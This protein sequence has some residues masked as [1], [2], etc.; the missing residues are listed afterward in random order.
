LLALKGWVKAMGG[1][2]RGY[3]SMLIVRPRLPYLDPGLPVETTAAEPGSSAIAAKGPMTRHYLADCAKCEQPV[4]P[5]DGLRV[6]LVTNEL[7][8]LAR[9]P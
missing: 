8:R 3:V 1:A 7:C 4:I 5:W 9:R 6:N 2:F